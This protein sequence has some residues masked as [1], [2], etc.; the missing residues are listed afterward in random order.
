MIFVFVKWVWKEFPVIWISTFTENHWIDIIYFRLES[1]TL[2]PKKKK[3]KRPLEEYPFHQEVYYLKKM[4]SQFLSKFKGTLNFFFQTLFTKIFDWKI[5][6]FPR[7]SLKRF[8]FRV[9]LS[10]SMF[11]LL[12]LSPNVNKFDIK[13]P[14]KWNYFVEI[15]FKNNIICPPHNIILFELDFKEN[16]LCY[17]LYNF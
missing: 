12:G 17:V 14:K 1:N 7:Q 4:Y 13:R 9:K 3:R 8:T 15:F 10:D 2:E 11:F 5:N 16:F 6:I